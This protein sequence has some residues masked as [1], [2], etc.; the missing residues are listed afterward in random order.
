MQGGVTLEP[1]GCWGCCCQQQG[2]G[3]ALAISRR[4]QNLIRNQTEWVIRS[5][6]A[7]LGNVCQAPSP[8]FLRAHKWKCPSNMKRLLG[9]ENPAQHFLAFVHG[10]SS[11]KLLANISKLIPATFLGDSAGSSGGSIISPQ[12]MG[13]LR[14]GAVTL[15]PRGSG[16]SSVSALGVE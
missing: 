13:K 16:R 5:G 11:S 4:D 15:P 9:E 2:G 6:G 7:G 10:F 8:A 12:Q 14:H 1:A 3:L